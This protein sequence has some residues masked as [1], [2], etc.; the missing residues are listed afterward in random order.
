VILR[1]VAARGEVGSRDLRIV[2]A[3][4]CLLA[5][6]DGVALVTLALRAKELSGSGM[7]GGVSI[8]ALFI[9]L[10][11]PLVVL[12]G[13]SGSSSTVSRRAAC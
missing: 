1:R 3:A 12:A 10:W 9:C 13:T 2:A 4:I 5:L 7:G 6:G 11:A 8:A